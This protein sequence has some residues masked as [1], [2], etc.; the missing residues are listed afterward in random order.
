MLA[1]IS[2]VSTDEFNFVQNVAATFIL[3]HFS[4]CNETLLR[5][6]LKENVARINEPYFNNRNCYLDNGAAAELS[7]NASVCFTEYSRDI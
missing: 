3:Q 2:G 7:C 5:D 1:S 4:T 6:K